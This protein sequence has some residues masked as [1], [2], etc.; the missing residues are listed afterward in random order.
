MRNK[1]FHLEIAGV[2]VVFLVWIWIRFALS[3]GLSFRLRFV[4]TANTLGFLQACGCAAEQVGGLTK[5][6]TLVQRITQEADKE[7]IGCIFI[8]GGN[9]AGDIE[10]SEVILECLKYLG[11]KAVLMGEAEWSLGEKFEQ[12]C[13][14]REMKCVGVNV[15]GKEEN[16]QQEK[17]ASVKEFEVV[18]IGKIK[19]AVSCFYGY[20]SVLGK[21]IANLVQRRLTNLLKA[22]QKQGIDFLLLFNY[23]KG[24]NEELVDF[25]NEGA[26]GISV[27]LISEGADKVAQYRNVW[28]IPMPKQEEVCAIDVE[29]LGGKVR[30]VS[31]SSHK[32]TAELPEE[33]GVLKLVSDYYL[34]QQELVLMKGVKSAEEWAMRK[35]ASARECL[36]CHY[37][38]YLIWD[39]SKHREAFQ[40]LQEKKRIVKECLVCHSE[41]YR[42]YGGI[43]LNKEEARNGVECSSCHG[44][45]VAHST[46]GLKGNVERGKGKDLCLTCHTPEHSPN[47]NYE[48]GISR[49]K[50]W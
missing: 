20:A 42:R 16:Q 36:D 9:L 17:I 13:K 45:A 6:A 21:R 15:D 49:I 4:V 33:P 47:F 27:L 24:R 8:D 26:K 19:V 29:V 18:E 44:D 43:D 5:K 3:N 22:L 30:G 41:F 23:L 10:R 35:Y 1:F 14:E 31:V 11:C 25:L 39:K 28:T 40:V 38:E 12:A 34:R 48:D 7:G 2:V 50:H 32:V 37:K 46:F